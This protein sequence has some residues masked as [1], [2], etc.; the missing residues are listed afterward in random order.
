[1]TETNIQIIRMF[2]NSPMSEEITNISISIHL[3]MSLLRTNTNFMLA[4]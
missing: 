4:K 2:I 1:M 3:A